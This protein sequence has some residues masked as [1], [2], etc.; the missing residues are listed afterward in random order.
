MLLLLLP[1]C[2]LLLLLLLLLPP[3]FLW[4][5]LQLLQPLHLQLP[6]LLCCCLQLPLPLQR[7]L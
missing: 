3:R 2:L 5:L 6:P 7:L 1:L 4:P